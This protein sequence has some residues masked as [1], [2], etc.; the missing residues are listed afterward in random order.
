M[1]HL[2][3]T[4]K[5]IRYFYPVIIFGITDLNHK[6]YPIVFMITSHETHIDY[7]HFFVSLKAI[8]LKLLKIKFQCLLIAAQLQQ[9]LI[10]EVQPHQQQQQLLQPQ[11]RLLDPQQ[12]LL[13]M[14]AILFVE[15]ALE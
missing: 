11:Q 6:F 7:I 8:A 9:H 4:Y 14:G 2:D 5:I 15:L 13:R 1:F 10:R 12:L 3:A